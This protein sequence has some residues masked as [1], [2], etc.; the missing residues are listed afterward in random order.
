MKLLYYLQVSLNQIL[1][2]NKIT[3]GTTITA[4]IAGQMMPCNVKKFLH[5]LLFAT[6]ISA[7]ATVISDRLLTPGR[8]AFED[9]FGRRGKSWIDSL[10]CYTTPSASAIS[11]GT[12]IFK[13]GDYF[14]QV[15][16]PACAALAFRIFSHSEKLHS[17]LPSII[18]ASAVSAVTSVFVSPLV[19]SLVGIPSELNAALA[20]VRILL[21]LS[22]YAISCHIMFF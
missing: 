20:H 21:K 8:N 5:P 19:G 9:G 6:A 11:D 17:E 3:G 22:S 2:F 4:L 15:L 1:L 14:A 13:T 7:L 10:M 12:A 18:A 16:G